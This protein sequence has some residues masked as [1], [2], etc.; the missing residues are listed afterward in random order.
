MVKRWTDKQ[1]DRPLDNRPDWG[2][3]NFQPNKPTDRIRFK[4]IERTDKQIEGDYHKQTDRAIDRQQNRQANFLL[5]YMHTDKQTFIVLTN[6]FHS[7]TTNLRK[8]S[9]LPLCRS[10]VVNPLY[11]HCSAIASLQNFPV[12]EML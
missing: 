3:M 11:F 2:S 8:R 5:T 10:C 12:N 6:E 9:R 4:N 1:K 7:L